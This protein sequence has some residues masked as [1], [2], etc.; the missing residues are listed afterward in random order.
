MGKLN[1]S[2]QLFGRAH[3]ES[4]APIEQLVETK[5]N[6]TGPSL[7]LGLHVVCLYKTFLEV[8]L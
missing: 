7:P 4:L 3:F 5:L 2:V 8:L 6:L 1:R